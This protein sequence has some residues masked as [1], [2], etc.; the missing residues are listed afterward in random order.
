M[1]HL[2]HIF[3]AIPFITGADPH[4]VSIILITELVPFQLGRLAEDSNSSNNY[5]PIARQIH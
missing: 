1:S 4:H 3:N 5:T 2:P